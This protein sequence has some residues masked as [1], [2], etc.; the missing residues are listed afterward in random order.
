M[1]AAAAIPT[2]AYA[3]ADR[4]KQALDPHIAALTKRFESMNRNVN[5]RIDKLEAS[6][7]RMV[8]AIFA[9]TALSLGI[10]ISSLM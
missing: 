6:H 8:K 10:D 1:I 7:K 2:I 3:A 5:D 4:G 9:L